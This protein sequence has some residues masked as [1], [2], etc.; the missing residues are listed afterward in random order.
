MKGQTLKEALKS[1][2][3]LAVILLCALAGYLIYSQIIGNP[4]NFEGGNHN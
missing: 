1:A 2:F 3:V 4:A